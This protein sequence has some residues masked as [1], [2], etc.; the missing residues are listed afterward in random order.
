VNRHVVELQILAM[1]TVVGTAIM[2]YVNA[3]V[4]VKKAKPTTVFPVSVAE[5]LSRLDKADVLGFRRARQCGLLIHFGNYEEDDRSMTFVVRSSNREVARFNVSLT[6][7]AKGT[8]T[9][10][11]IPPS[12]NGGEMYDGTQDY[13]HPALIQPLRPAV[14]ELIEAAMAQRPFDNERLPEPHAMWPKESN[15]NC[16]LG[17]QYLARGEPVSFDDPPGIS[18]SD[19]FRLYKN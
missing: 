16:N 14:Q 5:A 17:Q 2:G 18:R 4:A 9:A 11:R 6:P 8:A 7:T 3:P 1:A 10:I 12:S 19:A 13:A 15:D